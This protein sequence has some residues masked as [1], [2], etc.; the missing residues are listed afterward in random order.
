ME[1]RI[2]EMTDELEKR[3]TIVHVEAEL[4]KRPTAPQVEAE[5]QKCMGIIKMLIEKLNG[6]GEKD[7]EFTFHSK[8]A[9]DNKPTPWSGKKTRLNFQS[10]L[11][12]SRTGQTHFTKMEQQ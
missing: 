11:M 9:S 1:V 10:F 8:A 6:S 4:T 7:G 12:P 2:A 5:I 3:P